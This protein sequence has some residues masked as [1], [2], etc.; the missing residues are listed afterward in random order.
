MDECSTT[1]FVLRTRAFGESDR[2]VVALTEALGKISAIAKGARRSKRRFAG[3][4]LEPFH[5]TQIRISPRPGA[6]LAFLH[7]SRALHT[8]LDIAADLDAFA[9]ASYLSELTESMTVE[10]D[11]CPQVYGLYRQT[12]AALAGGDAAALGH[13]FIL[14]LLD[15][16]GWAPNFVRCGVC[17]RAV[18]ETS[19]PILDERA[20]GVI[21]SRHEAEKLGVDPTDTS[22]R[23]SRR[24]IQPDLID[25]VR[26]AADAPVDQADPATADACSALLDRLVDLHLDRVLRSREFLLSLRKRRPE[27]DLGP[28]N[29]ANNDQEESA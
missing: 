3:P 12:L 5:E 19:R 20:S 28:D 26:Q 15:H 29:P 27:P 25:Y 16:A 23:P 22:F 6:G 11:P 7:E 2:I 18:D 14:N 10:R 21:C 9:W 4:A 8:A 13:H 17:N 1:A 24:V